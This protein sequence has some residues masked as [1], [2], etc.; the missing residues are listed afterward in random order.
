MSTRHQGPRTSV[1]DLFT[2]QQAAQPLIHAVVNPAY[3]S[4]FPSTICIVFKFSKDILAYFQDLSPCLTTPPIYPCLGACEVLNR[5][6][7]EL[8]GERG[9]VSR[10][11]NPGDGVQWRLPHTWE[12]RGPAS[13][14]LHGL[15]GT[16][17]YKGE[18]SSQVLQGRQ[19]LRE[20]SAPCSGKTSELVEK[21]PFTGH[22]NLHSPYF[23]KATWQVSINLLP[24][25]RGL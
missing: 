3:C 7:R 20:K 9:A 15:H 18:L 23:L 16:G 4:E 10:G 24:R 19:K 11:F 25:D 14:C 12:L 8:L 17:Q 6:G 13:T 22:R 2:Q 5:E 1:S 21:T